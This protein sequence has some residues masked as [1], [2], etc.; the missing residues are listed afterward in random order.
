MQESVTVE[1][2][3]AVCLA[4]AVLNRP[5]GSLI[6]RKFGRLF[7]IG[8]AASKIYSH[9]TRT[10]W[11]C[12]CRCGVVKKIVGSSLKRGLSK[13]CGCRKR[14]LI[15][16]ASTK[17]LHARRG[18]ISPEYIAYCNAKARCKPDDDHH[19]DYFD[20]GIRFEFTSFK[21]FLKAL[22][23]PDNPSGLR[24]SPA[25]TVDRIDNDKSY[26]RGN[27]RWAS[28]HTQR[29]NQRPVKKDKS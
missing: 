3:S 14:D 23:T 1:K 27:I 12:V 15:V 5:K 17:H 9:W 10:V 20:R 21:Q 22:K 28:R 6:G 19:A 26:A 13:S 8:Q 7:V 25:H 24:P 29:L 4:Q 11:V 16:K 2:G 18:K